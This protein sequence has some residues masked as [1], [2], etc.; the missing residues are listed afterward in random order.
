ML[1]RDFLIGNLEH[2]ALQFRSLLHPVYEFLRLKAYMN[3]FM[4][5]DIFSFSPFWR[6]Q[7]G[8]PVRWLLESR[9]PDREGPSHRVT[10]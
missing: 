6:F 5:Y 7:V 8:C 9:L 4:V 1:S 10:P 2:H 3:R